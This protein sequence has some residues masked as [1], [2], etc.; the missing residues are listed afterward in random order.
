MELKEFIKQL[1]A[2]EGASIV[3]KEKETLNVVSKW[4]NKRGK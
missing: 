2:E 1:K 4:K 3:L